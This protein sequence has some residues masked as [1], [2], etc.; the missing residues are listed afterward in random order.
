MSIEGMF[1]GKL[2]RRKAYNQGWDA[3]DQGKPEDSCPYNDDEHGSSIRAG[4]HSGWQNAELD[5]R[6]E[7]IAK[8]GK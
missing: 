6:N 8:M 5:R 2:T 7:I 1:S 4:W 3:F